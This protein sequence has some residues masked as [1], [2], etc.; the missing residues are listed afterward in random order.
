MD[1]DLPTEAVGLR[2][3]RITKSE[4]LILCE[5]VKF[6]TGRAAVSTVLRRA[7]ISGLVKVDGKIENHFADIL[8]ENGDLVGTVTLDAA[9]YGA[10][11]NRWMRCK[12]DRS[13]V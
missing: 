2:L 1:L 6:V 4:K 12:V 10:L 13:F 7:A 9:S 5:P 8:A 3:A 11:K